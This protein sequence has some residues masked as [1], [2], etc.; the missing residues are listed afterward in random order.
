LKRR[1]LLHVARATAAAG[2][3][4]AVLG[5]PAALA[6]PPIA[7]TT[8]I[9]PSV[10]PLTT[11]AA[12]VY[13]VTLS[14]VPDGGTVTLYDNSQQL[15]NCGALPLTNG[16]ATCSATVS[17]TA[18]MHVISS[19]YPGYGRYSASS[20]YLP[21]A[22]AT[23]STTVVTASP[24]LADPG[25]AMTYTAVVS[26]RPEVGGVSVC[27]GGCGGPVETVAFALDGDPVSDC[28]L[29]P[30]D[31]TTGV[32]T[33]TTSVAP[34]AGGKHV[35]TAAYVGSQD[36]FLT[37]S[38]GTDDFAVTAPAVA[39]SSTALGFGSVTVGAAGTQQVTVT[40]TGTRALALAAASI[41]GPFTIASSTCSTSLAAGASCV[42][43]LA[44]HPAAAGAATGTLTIAS[45][46]GSPA[47]ALTGTG[48]A[49]ATAP[50]GAT[51][52]PNSKTTFTATVSDSGGPSTVT[53]PLRCP[54][55]V[56]CTLDG[57]VVISTSD[58]LKRTT[59]R[60]AAVDTQTVARFA[61]VRVAAGKVKAI[62]LKLSPA[63]IKAAQ[64]RGIRLIHATL[65]VNTSFT[66]GTK[67]TRQEQVV[68]RIPKAVKR[69][70]V[71]KPAQAPRFTG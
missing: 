68:I 50:T 70:S 21:L 57:T 17:S 37:T 35:V 16:V 69:K 46:A 62:K 63:F 71:S 4:L 43:T 6:T 44:F 33:C 1:T 55:G 20:K 23:P 52:P 26:P 41:S 36:A 3:A 12:V 9:T 48:V 25:A 60:A 66:D 28:L 31:I 13:T 47:V 39:L 27:S 45:D 22:V 11:G 42:V 18:G 7:V 49:A 40:N 51:L 54:D 34:V 8:T 59:V 53:V 56:A 58:L 67:A 64:K 19:L 29:R 30:V 2:L 61:G 32:A 5:T 65:T 14:P 15:P 24:K 10:S 38:G